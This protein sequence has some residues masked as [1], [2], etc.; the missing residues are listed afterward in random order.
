MQLRVSLV[1]VLLEEVLKERIAI[2]LDSDD[3]LSLAKLCENNNIK[4]RLLDFYHI[5]NPR[6]VLLNRAS[7]DDGVIL[8]EEYYLLDWGYAI[9]T[10]EE[11]MKKLAEVNSNCGSA[12]NRY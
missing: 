3:K 11:F 10:L 12:I 5:K 1:K 4:H 2:K 6:A 7:S 8:Y 9:I